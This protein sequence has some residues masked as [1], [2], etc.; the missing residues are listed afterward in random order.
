MKVVTSYTI[1]NDAVGIRM[2]VSFSEVDETTGRVINDNNRI[3][4]VITDNQMKSVANNLKEYAQEF[5]DE[6]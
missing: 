6:E 1:F 4:R 3:D 2:S 5:V